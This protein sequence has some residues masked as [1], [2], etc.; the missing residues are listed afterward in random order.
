MD[1]TVLIQHLCP[2][3]ILQIVLQ[4]ILQIILQGKPAPVEKKGKSPR[5]SSGMEPKHLLAS[6]L[7]VDSPIKI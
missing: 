3:I 2:Q 5:E 7:H 1:M 4:I 6:I